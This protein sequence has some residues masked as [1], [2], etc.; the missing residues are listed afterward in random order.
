MLPDQE[1]VESLKTLVNSSLK[2]GKMMYL[3]LCIFTRCVQETHSCSCSPQAAAGKRAL[4][5]DMNLPVDGS[6]SVAWMESFVPVGE[7]LLLLIC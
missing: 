5:S 7:F 4:Q 6:V 1:V 2:R 3:M